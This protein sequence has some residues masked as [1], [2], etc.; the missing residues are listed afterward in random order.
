GAYE[1]VP[2]RSDSIMIT[3]TPNA[4]A[5]FAWMIEAGF[6]EVNSLLEVPLEQLVRRIADVMKVTSSFAQLDDASVLW[7]AAQ[8]RRL[9]WAEVCSVPKVAANPQHLFRQFFRDVDWAGPRVQVPGPLARFGATPAPP[10]RPP[11]PEPVAIESL[12]REWA[13]P[14]PDAGRTGPDPGAKPLDGL[15]VLDLTHVLAGPHA[16]RLLGDLGAD[17][18]KLQTAERATSVNDP[19]FPYFYVWNRSKRDIS[20]NMAHPRAAEM[21]RRLVEHSDVVIENFSA[22]VLDRWGLSYE[23]VRSWNPRIVYVTMSGCGHEG[24]WSHLLTYAPTIHAL[25]GLTYLS[26]PRGRTDV[27]PGFS[28]NDHAAGLSAAVAVLA[29]LEARERTGEGQHV[30]ISQ[31][32]TGTYIV[33]AALLDLLSN[34]RDTEPDGNVDPFSDVAPNECYPTAD[35]EWVAV[36][37]RDDDEWRRLLAATGIDADPSLAAAPARRQRLAEVDAAVA[38]WALTVT[39]D[40]AQERL[41]AV[42]VPAGKVQHPGHLMEDPQLRAR[43]LWRTRDHAV[44]GE[45]PYDRFPAIWSG[46]TLEPYLPSPTY[47]G[48]HNFEVYGA[49]AGLDETE[50]AVGISDN[51][52]A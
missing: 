6:E 27:G 5:V 51:L 4:P 33:G 23:T 13:Q 7:L 14:R 37:C 25:S 10:P 50:I 17:V 47:V 11:D 43:G 9:A 41:Q 22:G 1:V 20:L 24:P 44:F 46:T 19:A 29:A 8:Q 31:M 34:G 32:E 12:V 38:A 21:A 26:N 35:H 45:R 30:D 18:V 28:L 15:R 16:T 3:V 2:A 42:G 49:L 48:E 36:T 52:F 39:A 40:E